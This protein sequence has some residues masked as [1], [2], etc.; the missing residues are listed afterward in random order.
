MLRLFGL[1]LAGGQD[2][3]RARDG[4]GRDL[5]TMLP[6]CVAR[7]IEQNIEEIGALVV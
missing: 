2:A 7:T 4:L 6:G 5:S 3:E 1:L